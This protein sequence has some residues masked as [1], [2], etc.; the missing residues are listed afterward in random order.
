MK[1]A[2]IIVDISH[3]KVDK[4]FT[5]AVPPEMEDALQV[6]MVVSIPF[7]KGD[8]LRK[9]Y[10]VSLSDECGYDPA[11]LKAIESIENTAE[12]TESRLILLASWI[13]ETYGCT[14][15][16]A[17]RTVFPIREEM[18]A[19]EKRRIYAADPDRIRQKIG[20]LSPKRY[21]ARIRLLEALLEA[22]EEGLDLT[23][24]SKN[25]GAS[26]SVT[27]PLA[28][29]GLIVI[30]QE[31]AWRIPFDPSTMEREE[32]KILNRS[33]AEALRQIL[34][35][36]EKPSPRP[37]LLKGVTG[38]GK[39][40][41]YMELIRRVL[42]EG[43]QAIV[44]IPEIALTY[45]TLRRFYAQFGNQVS[46]LHSRLSAGERYD[47]FRRARSGDARIMVGPRSALFT[48]FPDLGLIIIDEEHEPAYSSESTPRYLSRDTAVFRASCEGARVVMGSATPSMEAYYKASAGE[49]RLVT[50]EGRHENR[51]LP[52]VAVVDMREE[53]RNGNRSVLSRE[54]RQ[55]M[56]DS[57]GRGE[58]VM[59]FLN[60][61]GYAGFV[62]CRS[63]GYVMKCPHCD[64]SLSQ[65]RAA[66]VSYSRQQSAGAS[67]E[68][69]SAD[70]MICHYCGYETETP[71][72]C[73]DCGSRYIGGFRAGTEQ[74]EQ[75]LSKEFP[76]SRILR[77][78]LDTTRTRGSYEKILSGFASHE[79]DI[80][81]GTQMIVKGH[82]FPDVTL[83]GVLSADLSLNEADF[84]CGERTMQLLMQ[85]AGRSGRGSRPGKAVIQTYH[86][87]HYSIQAAASQDYD[88]FYKE[89][90]AYR[91]LMNYP[92]AAHLL[93]IHGT[94]EEEG[95]LHKA[96][97]FLRQFAERN[98]EKTGL[99]TIGPAPESISRINDMY[100]M[101]LYLRHPDEKILIRIRKNLEKYVEVNTGFRTV[102]LQYELR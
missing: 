31:N 76:E 34:E 79:A 81:I 71:R 99:T 82:D 94:C 26:S 77:M 33:Q 49:Y 7:G 66:R 13:R 63:C 3:E 10:V 88:R 58:Q 8:H 97:F 86:P 18:K 69:N 29:E 92:P 83:V 19:R 32:K 95:L 100:R 48:P 75:I 50:L 12:T 45:Q 53:L 72:E 21:R 16:Q 74:I 54:L 14:T 1:Y 61:R 44:L 102:Y 57:L 60:R 89:E 39:T 17:L 5:Y 20:E 64:V 35:E 51:A 22:G 11:R 46:V 90:I 93:I 25:L 84:R 73:P 47:Q 68:G 87:E 62:S 70:K 65:H 23:E 98:R 43:K 2:G 91:M 67:H 38:S 78:D 24:A 9:G 96:M 41:V 52:E 85:A 4:S 40:E 42:A 36:W 55:D 6:G 15:I 28:E 30:E 101:A 37:V 80:L 27:A 56:E 59:L